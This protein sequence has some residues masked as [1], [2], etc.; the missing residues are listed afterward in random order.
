MPDVAKKLPKSCQKLPK[1]AKS[2]Q[3]WS[4]AVNSSKKVPDVAK[5]VPKEAKLANVAK[6]STR[7]LTIWQ[8]IGY[9]SKKIDY[10]LIV[11]IID[12]SGH[13]AYVVEDV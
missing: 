7:L 9:L 5:K 2:G 1:V 13:P 4:K 11:D 6:L 12:S 10:Q 3:K 8:M